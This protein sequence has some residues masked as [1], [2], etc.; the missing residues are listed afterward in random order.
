MVKGI[1]FLRE[2]RMG[3]TKKRKKRKRV[4]FPCMLFETRLLSCWHSSDNV[5]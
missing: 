5:I 3:K 2:G 1:D 4:K